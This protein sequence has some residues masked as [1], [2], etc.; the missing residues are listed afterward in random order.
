MPV[1]NTFPVLSGLLW[2]TSTQRSPTSRF[3]QSKSSQEHRSKTVLFHSGFAYGLGTQSGITQS[4]GTGARLVSVSRPL[5]AIQA[6][7]MSEQTTIETTMEGLAGE[8]R[9]WG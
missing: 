4:D 1:R 9:A 3:A 5:N 7:T 2:L 6:H 8:E